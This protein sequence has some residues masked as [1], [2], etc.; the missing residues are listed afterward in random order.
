[1]MDA[2]TM[3]ICQVESA[4]HTYIQLFAGGETSL[5]DP[6]I[7]SWVAGIAL[8]GIPQTADV[9][10]MAERFL[11]AHQQFQMAV[12][13]GMSQAMVCTDGVWHLVTQ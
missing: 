9:P 5:T 1:M 8:L 11:S 10:Q 2:T 13:A 12:D 4:L 6:E 7:I 3:R